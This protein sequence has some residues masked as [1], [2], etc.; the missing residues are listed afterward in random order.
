MIITKA[1]DI[2]LEL[3][4]ALKVFQDRKV[5]RLQ[6]RADRKR[7]RANRLFDAGKYDRTARLDLQ[8][9]ALEKRIELLRGE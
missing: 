7:W 2:T 5:D 3:L 6:G 4:E 1:L 9:A 8:V